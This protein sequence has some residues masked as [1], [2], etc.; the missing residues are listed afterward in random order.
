MSA[1]TSKIA[2]LLQ[3]MGGEE[4]EDEPGAGSSD[5]LFPVVGPPAS[6]TESESDYSEA[7]DTGRRY[8]SG[9]AESR[10]QR[11]GDGGTGFDKY[12]FMEKKV[13]LLMHEKQSVQAQLEHRLRAKDAEIT[14]LKDQLHDVVHN[15]AARQSEVEAQ[16]P[17]FKLQIQQYKEQLRD[18][19]ISAAQYQELASLPEESLHIVDEVKVAVYRETEELKKDNERIRL[20]MASAR[21]S[22]ARCEEDNSRLKLENSRLGASLQEKERELRLAADALQSRVDRL[23]S[24]LE[25][26]LI[27]SELLTAKGQMYDELRART[28]KLESENQRLQ[29]VEATYVRLEKQSSEL[30]LYAR[31]KEHTFEMLMMDKA[32]LSKQVGWGGTAGCWMQCLG[33]KGDGVLIVGAVGTAEYLEGQWAGALIA[34]E[35]GTAE[36]T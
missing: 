29:V 18:L 1:V 25:Q 12:A 28:E 10:Q 24:E 16:A 33:W 26:S 7:A 32:H 9:G 34:G 20:S 22:L 23:A 13:H 5:I 19:R 8:V 27:R 21:E 14:E 17:I 36:P 4:E 2:R 15:L 35:V 30:Q 6:V 11:G 3:E 31:D